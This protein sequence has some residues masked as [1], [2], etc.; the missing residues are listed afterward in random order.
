MSV[1]NESPRKDRVLPAWSLNIAIL[2]IK[3]KMH[4]LS[5]IY[6]SVSERFFFKNSTKTLGCTLSFE[7]GNIYS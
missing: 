4:L 6:T 1:E 2:Q 3:K 7:Y 5:S